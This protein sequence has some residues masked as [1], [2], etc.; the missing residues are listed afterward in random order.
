MAKHP[1]LMLSSQALQMAPVA[2]LMTDE[3]GRVTWANDALAEMLGMSVEKLLAGSSGNLAQMYLK[4]LLSGDSVVTLPPVGGDNERWLKCWVQDMPSQ[5]G[6]GKIRYFADISE[7][8][9]TKDPVTGLLNER[10]LIQSLDPQVSRSRRYNNPL[11]VVAMHL[12]G[13][14]H[15]DEK[16]GQSTRERVLMAVGHLLKDQM[17]WA[18]LIGHTEEDDFIFVLPETHKEDAS[19]LISKINES[20]ARIDVAASNGDGIELTAHFGVA[21]W[22]KGD[23][24]HMLLQR[25]AQALRT[26]D[27]AEIV[28]MS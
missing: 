19:K 3:A 12:E 10:S 20:L 1:D 9:R 25:A 11:S 7:Y 14:E 5:S 24:T 15:M 17:R 23:D 21:E 8:I 6:G 2:M 16:H 26:V 27:N 4:R 22:Q 18:D 13:I 28:K